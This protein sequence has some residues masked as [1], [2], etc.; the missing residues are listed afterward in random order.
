MY[1]GIETGIAGFIASL[2]P[3]IMALC[4]LFL[5]R[6]LHKP[7]VGNT[8]IDLRIFILM[9]SGTIPSGAVVASYGVFQNSP[10]GLL[11]LVGAILAMPVGIVVSMMSAWF[12]SQG[13]GMLKNSWLDLWFQLTDPASWG[14]LPFPYGRRMRIL[15]QSARVG[16]F[17]LKQLPLVMW[18]N[19]KLGIEPDPENKE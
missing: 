17:D 15:R 2:I 7:F 11:W 9:I 5:G 8:K 13:P 1:S 16:H 18:V 3:F 19:R 10:F 4:A 6:W 12:Y 14:C